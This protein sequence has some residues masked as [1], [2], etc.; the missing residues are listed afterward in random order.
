M[1]FSVNAR[2]LSN[3]ECWM[4]NFDVEHL[5]C[6]LFFCLMGYG[7]FHLE[8]IDA[9]TQSTSWLHL[10]YDGSSYCDEPC[11][12][13]EGVMNNWSYDPITAIYWAVLEGEFDATKEK[14]TYIGNCTDMPKN[15]C[16]PD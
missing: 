9:S 3:C 8:I 1:T 7:P 13:W 2:P 10:E 16:I 4:S 6:N 14:M 5:K 11:N 15:M 12:T